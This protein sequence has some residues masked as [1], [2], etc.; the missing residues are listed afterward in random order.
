MKQYL[1]PECNQLSSDSMSLQTALAEGG[2]VENQNQGGNY[3][4]LQ[5]PSE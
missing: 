4:V 3:Q 5:Q 2:A 1:R